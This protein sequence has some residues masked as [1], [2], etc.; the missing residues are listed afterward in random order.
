[1][2]HRAVRFT[3]FSF[4]AAP[5]L[6]VAYGSV[7]LLVEGSREPGA[8]WIT[9]HLAFLGGVLL[10][11][12]V[13]S[14]LRRAAAGAAGP[15]RRAVVRAAWPVAL[16][17]VAAATA[18]AVIDLYAGFRAAD[19]AEMSEIFARVQNV[20][21]VMPVVYTVVPLFLYVGVIALLAALKGPRAVPSLVAFVL[22]TV[23]IAASLDFLPLGGLC[24]LLAFAPLRHRVGAP[25]ASGSGHRPGPAGDAA[26]RAGAGS[27]PGGM[28]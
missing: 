5:L 27:T 23:A 20:P 14:G 9:G 22:G 28:V 26:A 2:T 7:R 11:G 12:V 17:G 8:A 3:R 13:C 4:I 1:M 16:A 24:Y 21:G 6:L 25:Q 10:F 19:K 15:A 18:Q